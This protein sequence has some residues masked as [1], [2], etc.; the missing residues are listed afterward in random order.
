MRRSL[1]RV[2][3]FLTAGFMAACGGKVV[4][5]G[6]ADSGSASSGAGGGAASSSSVS[7]AG[8]SASCDPA[9]H[10]IDIHDFNV[11]CSVDS[12]CTPVFAGN[13]CQ[14]CVCPFSAINSSDLAKYEAER[15]VKSMGAPPSKCDCPA[16]I[17]ACNMGACTTHTP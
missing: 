2:S 6:I 8:G 13:F 17:V 10:T 11:S 15:M 14:G 3:V 5:D 9:T 4:F 1:A 16:S 7:G 12:D